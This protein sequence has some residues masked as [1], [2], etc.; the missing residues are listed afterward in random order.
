MK[1]LFAAVVVLTS[2]L[3]LSL[4]AQADQQK[5][6]TYDKPIVITKGGTYR[7]N[8]QSLDPDVAAVTVR[9]SEPV[10][11]EYSNIQSRGNLIDSR[12][13]R[14]NLTVRHT[15]GIGLNPARPLSENRHPGRFLHL[16]EFESAR[17]EN[18]YME[19][20]SGIYFRSFLGNA[21][22][23][24]T[25]T[26][27]R[28]Q[29]RNIDGRKSVGADQFSAEK[30]YLVQFV[31]FNNIRR[32]AD[33]E[34][35][36]NEIINEPGKSRVEEVINLFG[37]SGTPESPIRIHDNYIQGAF[38][39]QPQNGT[40][41]GGGIML[42]DGGSS[43]MEGAGGYVMAYRN[44]VVGTSNQGIVVAAGNNIK[45]F[46]NRVIS[47]G[48]LPDG[49]PIA[50][51]NV[52]MYVWDAYGDKKHKTFFNIAVYDNVIGWSTPLKGSNAQNP[53]WFPDCTPGQCANNTILP[54]PV[55]LQTERDEKVLW[56]RKLQNNRVEIGPQEKAAAQKR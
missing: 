17:I 29:V 22:L 36:W 34:I 3:S 40:Y 42:G 41:S 32:V 50:S 37:S 14:A 15:R 39:A 8:W 16:E 53:V 45:V 19:G 33:A 11:I 5:N 47:S 52:G 12:Y 25:I 46:E 6:I 27:V 20:T 30:Y 28:N 7:G 54:G 24:Q 51:Q 4:A 23:G 55:T 38:A 56:Q 43:S 35:A 18:N 31:Q 13:V 10:V 26:V 2:T 48:L 1:S 21:K 44:Q 49:R 9:T